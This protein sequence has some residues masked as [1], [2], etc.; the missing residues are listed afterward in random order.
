MPPIL[1]W[2]ISCKRVAHYMQKLF[3]LWEDLKIK[4]PKSHSFVVH[5]SQLKIALPLESTVLS[6]VPAMC[7]CLS[8]A[9]L[10]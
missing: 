8:W 3:V 1:C 6:L 4:L 9:L 5:L 7:C 2:S 10:I